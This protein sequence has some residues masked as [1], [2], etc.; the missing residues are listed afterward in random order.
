MQIYRRFFGGLKLVLLL[1]LVLVA[2][3]SSVPYI[4]AALGRYTVDEILE[5]RLLAP[6]DQLAEV[7]DRPTDA[8]VLD[9][10]QLGRTRPVQ[11]FQSPD[12]VS[13]SSA[14]IIQDNA[15]HMAIAANLRERPA[16]LKE[17]LLLKRGK[18]RAQKTRLLLI[19]FAITVLVYVLHSVGKVIHK[20]LLGK[21]GEQV[22]F[23]LRR[24]LHHKLQ[25][26][27]MTYHDQHEKG[28]LMARV[29]DDVDVIRRMS[30]HLSTMLTV[31]VF[32][33]LVGVVVIL[34][35]NVRLSLLAL[36]SLPLFGIVYSHFRVRLRMLWRYLA[37]QRAGIYGLAGDR[38]ASPETVKGF[39][40]ERRESIRLFKRT[41]DLLTGE[42][43]QVWISGFLRLWRTVVCG[44]SMAVVLGYGMLLVRDGQ[45]SIGYLLFFYGSL[46]MMYMPVASIS[47]LIPMIQRFRVSADRVLEVLDEPVTIRSAPQAVD[48]PS[49]AGLICMKN[50][51]LCYEG[52]ESPAL[53][54]INLTIEPG[55]QVCLM[56]PS[57]AGKTSLVNLLLRLYEPSDGTIELDGRD[58]REIN[59]SS[60]RRHMAYV[61][62]DAFLFSGTL[63]DN[64]RYGN[65]LAGDKQVEDAAR[66]AELHDFVLTLPD[67]Y[68]TLVGERGVTLSGGQ[69]QRVSLARALLTDPRVLILDD[70][71]S[72]LDVI[73]EAR[74][75][76]TLRTVMDG[77]TTI[78]ITHRV[79]MSSRA[80]LIMVLKDGTVA[81]V[82]S[83]GKLLGKEGIYYDL[84]AEQLA[85]KDLKVKSQR[86]LSAAG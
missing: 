20:Y 70:C 3:E 32:T 5:V 78:V 79:S 53:K 34:L 48:L 7:P 38:L 15:D 66:A 40:Q 41:R 1:G 2:A 14:I 44:V 47:M 27:S 82:G 45:L 69:R 18:S 65:F 4:V 36:L 54:D 72:A 84:V 31:N 61:P 17:A 25:Q 16:Q 28:R 83:H 55:Q 13:G 35:I 9:R 29:I 81:E 62:Q 30:V 68:D 21:A 39:G 8:A 23:R 10:A 73:T 59:L 37:K 19:V 22:V 11:V 33:I 74:I 58:L 51:G 77:R 56:G 42:L 57:G 49:V 63:R 80:D 75:V 26:L 71:T 46:S 86:A 43:K 24:A 60:L 12:K 52:S 67:A 85:E 76:K 64:I 6:K 50:V